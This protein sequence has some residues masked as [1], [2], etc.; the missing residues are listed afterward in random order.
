MIYQLMLILRVMFWFREVDLYLISAPVTIYLN[1]LSAN[2][3]SANAE[4]FVSMSMCCGP[5]LSLRLAMRLGT[6]DGDICQL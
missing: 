6:R 1:P 2:K 3:T 5:D 4:I